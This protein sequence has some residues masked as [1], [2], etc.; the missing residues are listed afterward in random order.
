M[1]FKP[2]PLTDRDRF[3]LEAKG[4]ILL[5]EDPLELRFEIESGG[6]RERQAATQ[7]PDFDLE[8][9]DPNNFTPRIVQTYKANGPL[10]E[11]LVEGLRLVDDLDRL[12]N[13]PSQ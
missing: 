8:S 7:V 10:A 5:M 11:W 6:T 1:N 3:L 12:P 9:F 13:L 4:I 2:K